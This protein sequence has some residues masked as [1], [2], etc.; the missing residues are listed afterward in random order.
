MAKQTR[1]T[2]TEE[3]GEGR[4]RLTGQEER[5]QDL[6]ELDGPVVSSEGGMQWHGFLLPAMRR[7]TPTLRDAVR[8]K[9]GI[10][11]DRQKTCRFQSV[12]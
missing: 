8:L 4:G 11:G 7:R 5:L 12:V 2:R 1:M 3:G 9:R 6:P 10:T